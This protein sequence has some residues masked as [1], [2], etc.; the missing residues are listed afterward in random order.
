MG[1]HYRLG[2][3]GLHGCQGRP[4]RP[5]RHD[6]R[7]RLCRQ[8]ATVTQVATVAPR[9]STAGTL[10]LFNYSVRTAKK[11]HHHQNVDQF[12]NAV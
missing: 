6:R 8:V 12:V 3:P 10:L 11:T 7:G 9:T 1:R 5:G 2:C 4:G